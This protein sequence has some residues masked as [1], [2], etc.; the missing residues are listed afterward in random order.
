M[1]YHIKILEFIEKKGFIRDK[2]YS[3]LTERA[4]AT[5]SLDFKQLI[6]MGLIERKGKGRS[7]YYQ[8]KTK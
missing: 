8:L 7:T 4:K 6:D 1:D 5:R 2:D 3:K